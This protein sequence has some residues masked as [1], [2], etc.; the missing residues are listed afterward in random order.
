[1][2][3]KVSLKEVREHLRHEDERDGG[4]NKEYPEHQSSYKEKT[5]DAPSTP[6]KLPSSPKSG[7]ESYSFFLQQDGENKEYGNG[8]LEYNEKGFHMAGNLFVMY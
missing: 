5:I 3:S 6:V 1:M 2:L 4:E 8:D 7:G